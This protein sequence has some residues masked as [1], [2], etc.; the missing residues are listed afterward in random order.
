MTD[1]KKV[2][3]SDETSKRVCKHMNEDHGLTIYAMARKMA[4]QPADWHLTDAKLKKVTLEGCEI[5]AITCSGDL[6]A[7]EKVVYP[8][9]TPLASASEV[10]QRMIVIHH[11]ALSP[12]WGWIW[13]KPFAFKFLVTFSVLAYGSIVLGGKGMVAYL[14]QTHLLKSFYPRTDLVAGVL[15]LVFYVTFIAHIGEAAFAAHTCVTAFK[16]KWTGTLQWVVMIMLAG[17]PILT[18][19]MHL[20]SVQQKQKKEALDGAK[21][22]DQ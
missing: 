17:Y 18:E 7:M 13:T 14:D 22:K 1:E 11:S 19:L 6:C 21:A 10:K 12:E 16:L 8:F 20:Q 9:T 15:Q 5:Q 3:I 2:Q 4:D